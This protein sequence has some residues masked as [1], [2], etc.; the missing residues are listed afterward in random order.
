M[1]G[2]SGNR[3]IKNAL[4]NL[5]KM[6]MRKVTIKHQLS[7]TVDPSS[8][9]ME[10]CTQDYCINAIVLPEVN[11]TSQMNSATILSMGRNFS[12]GSFFD[13]VV[14]PIIVKKAR[15]EDV[16]LSTVDF[17]IVDSA[18]YDFKSV[19]ETQDG[20]SYFILTSQSPA[21]GEYDAN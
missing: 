4:Y 8:G 16:K 10:V 17:C 12:H 6:Y 7:V 9:L 19:G 14:A 3:M 1:L 18:R 13:K 15:V 20:S 2:M 21:V 11:T 5:E